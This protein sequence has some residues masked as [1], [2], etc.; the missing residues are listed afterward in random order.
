MN[1]THINPNRLLRLH[2]LLTTQLILINL[3]L[4]IVYL[5]ATF[6]LNNSPHVVGIIA[7]PPSGFEHRMQWIQFT[8][9]T[10]PQLKPS[11]TVGSLQVSSLS[12]TNPTLTGLL[13]DP[14]LF[15]QEPEPRQGLEKR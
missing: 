14:D 4:G 1:L 8:K 3:E 12:N 2:K 6:V 7:A 13:F 15:G 5:Q 9:D 11:T 10:V